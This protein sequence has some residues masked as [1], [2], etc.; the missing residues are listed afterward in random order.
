MKNLN[1]MLSNIKDIR[2][3]HIVQCPSSRFYRRNTAV[4][5]FTI[6]RLTPSHVRIWAAS[7]SLRMTE[8]GTAL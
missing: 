1:Q 3:T 5:T 8:M 6:Y 2:M 4:E 7:S